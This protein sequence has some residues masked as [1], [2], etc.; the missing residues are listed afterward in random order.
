MAKRLSFYKFDRALVSGRIPMERLSEYVCLD[1][2]SPVPQLIF[3]ADALTDTPPASYDLDDRI[4]QYLRSRRE[5]ERFRNETYTYLSAKS[6]VAEG[7]SWFDLPAFLNRLAIA[8]W[9]DE[10]RRLR[11][12]NIARWGHTLEQI[13]AK[14]EYITVLKRDKPDY[15]MFGAGGNDLQESLAKRELL[16]T[17][18]AGRLPA[19]YITSAGMDLFARIETTLASVYQEVSGL[20]PA[21]RI[22]CH[23]YDYPRPEVG[24]G[25][26]IG[27]YLT[28]LGIPDADAP[29][30]VAAIIDELNQRVRNAAVSYPSVTYLDC[31]RATKAYTWRDDMHPSNDGFEAL[32]KMFEDAMN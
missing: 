26:Y 19:D 23:G 30:I 3:R 10:H 21:M 12:N 27:Q 20:Y 9:I 13:V 25:R 4:Y 11:M 15:F 6:V 22:F 8:D 31:R 14:R 17:Y 16:F 32:A 18:Q 7:D 28:A 29:A 24:R 2:L 1:E 5:R